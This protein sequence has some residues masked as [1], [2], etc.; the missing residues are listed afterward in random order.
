MK[1]F[2]LLLL[3]FL[4]CSIPPCPVFAESRETEI[5]L[6]ETLE[7]ARKLNTETLNFSETTENLLSG[8]LSLSFKG[9][10]STVTDILFKEIKAHLSLLIKMLVLAVL[11]GVLCNLQQGMPQGGIS[12]ISFLAC[13]SAIAGLSVTIVAGLLDLASNTI[14]SLMLFIASLMPI[15]TGLITSAGQAAFAGF[16]P[17]LFLAM[18]AFVLICQQFFLPMITVITALSVIN[19]MSGRFHISRLIDVIKQIIKWGLGLLLTVFVGILSV[20]SFSAFAAGSVAGRTVKYALCNFVPL[21]GNVLAES[22]EA[23]I[24]S[25]RLIRGAV[26]FAGVLALVSLCALP[27]LKMLSV[28]F[29]YRFAAGIAEPATDQRIVRLLMDL[30]GN[31]TLVV[32]IMLMVSVMFIISIALL[33]GLL[34]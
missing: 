33:C 17:T 3:T 20:H 8:N 1:K 31:I 10:L 13:F 9:I 27:L 18:Q 14:D 29:L 25:V 15:M 23:V 30:A 4:L 5:I 11:A 6:E 26:G 2:L 16:Y 19:A 34:F 24:S 32:V 22:V 7:K 28:S 12:E 21:V